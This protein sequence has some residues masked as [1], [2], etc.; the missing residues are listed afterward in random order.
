MTRADARPQP[1]TPPEATGAGAPPRGGVGRS[2]A[3]FAL[4]TGLSRILGLVREILAAALYGTKG[5]INAFVIAFQ[6]PNLLRSLVADSALSAAFVPIYT[7]LQEEGR[8]DEARRL[9]GALLGVIT[10]VLGGLS[11]IAIVVAP[12]VMPLFA[13]G[14]PAEL[15]DELVLLARIMFPI[16]ALLG[17]TGLAAAVLQASG[18]FGA[19]AFVP[20]LWNLVIIAVM[21]LGALV[22]SGGQAVTLYAVGIVVGTLAQLLWLVPSFRRK[23][24]FP[25]S[26]SFAGPHLRRVMLLMLPV[27]LGLGLINVNLSIDSIFATLVSEESPR[28]IDAAFRIYL[29]PQGIF[30]VAISTVL[31]PAISRLA[32]R[33]DHDGMRRTVADGTRQ[34]FFMLLPCSA[35]LLVLT[36]P[37]VRLVFQRGE[38]NADSTALTSQA[39]F[40]F[41]LGLAFNGASLLVI[42]AFFSLQEP[43]IPTKV[44]ALGLVLNAALDAILFG[45]MGTGGIPL[46][47]SIASAVTLVVLLVVLSR[48]LGGLHGDWIREGL[49]RCLAASAVSALFAWALWTVLDGAL[50]RSLGAQVI[51]MSAAL[52]AATVGYVAAARAFDLHELGVLARL[53]RPLR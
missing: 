45:P 39:L 37:V 8:P 29:L 15:T 52:A 6:V 33:G 17:L 9:V 12:W 19:T 32:A 48:R 26:F 23:G 3:I 41:A 20:V 42:R 38:F 34:I 49:I 46:A 47:T 35:F 43:W 44:A 11:L 40:Y 14:L 25:L 21:G 22:V 7:K 50:G 10:L 31:F 18:E 1:P 16:V 53:M 30:S 24:P 2:T 5:P 36:E 27:T 4:W 13:P 28:A 51:T